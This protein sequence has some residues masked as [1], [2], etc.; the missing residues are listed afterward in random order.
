MDPVTN[1]IAPYRKWIVAALTLVTSLLA[2]GLLPES[3]S[4][5][6][7]SAVAVLGL[8]GV[9]AVPNAPLPA[10]RVAPAGEL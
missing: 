3:W 1:L 6:I 9:Y 10:D 7:S 2:M 4:G 8:L 5:G